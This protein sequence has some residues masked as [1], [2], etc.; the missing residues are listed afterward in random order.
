MLCRSGDLPFEQQGKQKHV[1]IVLI[2]CGPN[3]PKNLNIC[4]QPLR[5]ELKRAAGEHDL[6]EGY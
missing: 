2:T 6:L 5:E 1:A 4:M 3:E